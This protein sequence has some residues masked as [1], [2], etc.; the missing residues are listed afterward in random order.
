M[1]RRI[2]CW[3]YRQDEDYPLLSQD[4]RDKASCLNHATNKT[5]WRTEELW[6]RDHR[7]AGICAAGCEIYSLVSNATS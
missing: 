2:Y 7:V 4:I 5:R 6:S 3:N 1:V